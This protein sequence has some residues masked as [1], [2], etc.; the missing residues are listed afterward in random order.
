M[1]PLYGFVEGD[2]LG[3]LILADPEETLDSLARKTAASASVRVAA[4]AEAAWRVR[5]GDR[6]LDGALTVKAAG[7]EPLDRFDVVRGG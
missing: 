4:T 1:I 3:L 6:A 7:L 2:T 5:A